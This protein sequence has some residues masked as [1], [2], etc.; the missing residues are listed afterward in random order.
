MGGDEGGNQ[1]LLALLDGG[2]PLR[3]PGH[4][5]LGDPGHLPADLLGM[6]P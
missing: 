5:G 3:E 4:Q 1:R 2:G 6:T